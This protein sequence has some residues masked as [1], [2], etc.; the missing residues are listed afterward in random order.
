MIATL[1]TL[2]IL[3]YA[4]IVAYLY[5]NQR[6]LIYLPDK[7]VAAP[8]HYKLY[9]FQD[10]DTTAS[11]GTSIQLWYRPAQKG[12]PTVIYYHGNAGHLGDRAAIFDALAAKGFG[13]LGVEY[14]GYGK[15]GG[16]PSEAGLYDDAR[17]GMR[18]LTDQQH[19]PLDHILIYG[20]S[21]GTGVAVQMAS[22]YKVGALII[23][24]GYTSVAARAAEIYWYVPVNFL[25]QD[26]FYSLRKIASV[27]SPLLLFHGELDA[28]IPIAMGRALY[29]T[30]TS[31]KESIYFPHNGHNDFDTRIIAD[32]V[33]AFSHKHGLIQAPRPT[34]PSPQ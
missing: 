18:F 24:A 1:L 29:D 23:Q 19:I 30:A 8:E 33:L 4:A 32:H 21:L 3:A 17:A 10:I 22:E 25:I 20:E 27:K 2:L 13:V 12:F 6:H 26:K 16:S 28:V 31:P 34:S 11:D 5:F 14:R 7:N 9:G 15:S